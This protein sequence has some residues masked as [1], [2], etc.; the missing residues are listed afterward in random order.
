MRFRLRTIVDAD[1]IIV[2]KDGQVVEQGTH[3]QLLMLHGTYHDLWR[4]QQDEAQP[5]VAP[6]AVTSQAAVA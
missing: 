5:L 6:A 2:L 4:A 1:H 3:D